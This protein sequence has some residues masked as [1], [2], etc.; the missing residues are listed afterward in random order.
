[1]KEELNN[2]NKYTENYINLPEIK[3]DT[4]LSTEG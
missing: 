2:K 3:K 4:P 1:M